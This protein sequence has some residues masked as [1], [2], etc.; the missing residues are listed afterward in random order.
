RPAASLRQ[1][2]PVRVP[3]IGQPLVSGSY[4]PAKCRAPSDASYSLGTDSSVHRILL[5]F[6][7]LGP[8]PP[9][10]NFTRPRQHTRSSRN[11]AGRE[12]R[13]PPPQRQ[14]GPLQCGAPPNLPA[15]KLRCEGQRSTEYIVR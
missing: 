13:A 4:N 5:G 14:S 8:D 3:L 15:N 11:S 10:H 9:T 2:S 12:H 1:P 7:P 6:A